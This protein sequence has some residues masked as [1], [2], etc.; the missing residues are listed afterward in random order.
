VANQV[1]HFVTLNRTHPFHQGQP[2][3]ATERPLLENRGQ[4]ADYL[5]A[6]IAKDRRWALVYLPHGQEPARATLRLDAL[7]APGR[8]RWFDPTAGSFS[9][10]EAS[11]SPA[12]THTFRAPGRNQA[13]QLDW[14]LVLDHIDERQ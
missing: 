2:D 10:Y 13:G 14:V 3:W 6:L 7:R 9:N 11:L 8:A 5:A 1:K 4:G 12:G